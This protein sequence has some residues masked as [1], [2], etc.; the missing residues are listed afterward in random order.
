MSLRRQQVYTYIIPRVLYWSKDSLQLV[1]RSFGQ[2]SE[3]HYKLVIA[4]GLRNLRY[5]NIH[6]GD[7]ELSLL[8]TLC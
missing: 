8:S 4:F 3:D 6:G 2:G 1:E 7:S 5:D